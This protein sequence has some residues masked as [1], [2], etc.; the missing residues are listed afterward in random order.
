VLA[1]L[2][3][4]GEA[5]I[6]AQMPILLGGA[7][8]AA[9]L[10]TRPS[11]RG[12]LAFAI[13]FALPAPYVAYSYYA[14][15]H[16]E[17]ILRW[18]AQW[19]NNL[20]PDLLSLGMALLPQLGLAALIVPRLARRRSREDVFLLA[21]LL[22]L[23][24]ILWLPNPAGNLRRRFFD[25]IYLALVVMAA[26]GMFE[27]LVPRLKSLRSRRLV[28]F[29]YVSFA[30]TASI[31]LLLAPLGVA[32][33]TEY[34]MPQSDYDAMAWLASRP[35]GVVLSS[36]GMG[37]YVPAYTPDTVYV[38]QYSE[39][40]NYAEKARRAERLLTGQDDLGAFVAAN[41]VRY[42]L[43]TD[44]FGGQPPASLGPPAFYEPGAAVF[45]VRT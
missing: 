28:P 35:A 44:D 11:G 43:W 39:T 14:S 12:W 1:G 30:S 40:Y 38:G 21:W 33:S 8:L 34:S 17:A 37:L 32:R 19:R 16:V 27:V 9:L 24:A 41:H 6:H 4:L 20:P 13:A 25:G 10:W 23:A 22:L 26:R 36:A 5:S 42:V 15:T 2:A 7:L 18:S 31:F 3:W 45:V 29:A